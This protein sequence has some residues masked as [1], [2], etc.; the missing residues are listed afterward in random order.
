[1][2]E[3]IGGVGVEK[4]I[5]VLKLGFEYNIC[6]RLVFDLIQCGIDDGKKISNVLDVFP[7]GIIADSLAKL[8]NNGL[9]FIH[10]NTGECQLTSEVLKVSNMLE[11]EQITFFDKQEK[12][13]DAVGRI[14]KNFDGQQKVIL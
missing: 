9:I 3:L 2:S 14:L 12:A 13:K 10:M 7:Y 6:D 4:N 11:D 5:F 1:M 8:H